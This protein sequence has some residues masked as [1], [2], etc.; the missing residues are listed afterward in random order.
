[1]TCPTINTPPGC[2]IGTTVSQT[3]N[4]DTAAGGILLGGGGTVSNN[5]SAT[6]NGGKTQLIQ[7]SPNFSNG[8]PIGWIATGAN[9]A[10][11]T[12]SITV[13]VYAVCT[14]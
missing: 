4:C 10:I 9:N 6:G 8:T 7:T 12:S 2:G 14:K 1:M 3:V 11:V 13:T 5:D